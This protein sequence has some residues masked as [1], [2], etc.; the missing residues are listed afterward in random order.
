MHDAKPTWKTRLASEE[1]IDCGLSKQLPGGSKA[2][3]ANITCIWQR[4]PR[5]RA[6]H[7]SKTVNAEWIAFADKQREQFANRT[8]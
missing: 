4:N 5:T 1:S 3:R 6:R 2:L 8:S 7:I